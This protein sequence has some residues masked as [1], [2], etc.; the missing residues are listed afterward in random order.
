MDGKRKSWWKLEA[1]LAGVFAVGAAIT[2][3][4][5][6]WIEAFG[7]EPDSGTGTAEWTIV[8]ASGLAALIIGFLSRRHYISRPR[9]LEEG[10]QS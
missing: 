2:A 1:L 7:V 10:S 6:D 3:I 9:S 4:V 5:P 8:I